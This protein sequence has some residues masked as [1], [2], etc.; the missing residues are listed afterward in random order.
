[1][2]DTKNKILHGL[3]VFKYADKSCIP[4]AYMINQNIR[5]LLT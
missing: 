2:N 5:K 4:S 3:I 1:M